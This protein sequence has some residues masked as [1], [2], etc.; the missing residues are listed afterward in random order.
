[1]TPEVVTVNSHDI[2]ASNSKALV[3]M[4]QAKAIIQNCEN[5]LKA[6][7]ANEDKSRNSW[8]FKT[9]TAALKAANGRA[10]AGVITL[11]KKL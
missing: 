8:G 7:E 5:G 11:L 2:K 1:M 9:L 10:S 4:A 3:D 6:E